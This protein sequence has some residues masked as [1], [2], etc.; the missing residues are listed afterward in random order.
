MCRL[1]LIFCVVLSLVEA[2]SFDEERNKILFEKLHA[3]NQRLWTFINNKKTSENQDSFSFIRPSSIQISHAGRYKSSRKPSVATN[4]NPVETVENDSTVA[5]SNPRVKYPDYLKE[6]P[7]DKDLDFEDVLNTQNPH[8]PKGW[9]SSDLEDEKKHATQ[10]PESETKSSGKVLYKSSNLR[11]GPKSSIGNSSKQKA[12][13]KPNALQR[14]WNSLTHIAK[15]MGRPKPL[16]KR[17]ERRNF[18]VW[19]FQIGLR[20]LINNDSDGFKHD[21]E[22]YHQLG[23]RIDDRQKIFVE[24]K[25]VTMT[26]NGFGKVTRTGLGYQHY[27][28][29]VNEKS[30]YYP[31]FS[32]FYDHWK[33]NFDNFNGVSLVNNK[34]SRD[35]LTTRLGVEVPLTSTTNLDLY[36]ER[37]KKFLDYTDVLGS[38]IEI[39]ARNN[40]YGMGLSHSF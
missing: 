36:W 25:S 22:V 17:A 35:I 9:Q 34:S 4:Q 31:Y 28:K 21:A 6:D 16:S 8:R 32:L 19:S 24:R 10:A 11:T 29:S 7:A 39:H 23:Y 5:M 12:I 20:N 37:G 13:S 27:L 26:G 3:Q 33:G 1:I 30:D 18:K 15:S 40:L 2:N 38:K 14:A